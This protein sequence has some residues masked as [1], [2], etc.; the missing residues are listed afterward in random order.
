MTFTR[1]FGFYWPRSLIGAAAFL[2]VIAFMLNV[3]VAVDH[4][5]HSVSDTLY[6]VFPFWAGAFLLYDWL[7]RSTTR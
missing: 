3:W 6:G 1:R 4:R 2:G 7:G 5:S